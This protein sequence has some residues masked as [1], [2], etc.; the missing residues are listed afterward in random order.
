VL[1][2]SVARRA[3]TKEGAA[4]TEELVGTTAAGAAAAG[5]AASRAVRAATAA[6]L[7][8]IAAT[9]AVEAERK[10]ATTEVAAVREPGAARARS[11]RLQT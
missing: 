6:A 5:Q 7:G 9:P 4:K 2:E 11:K 10:E 8:A 3:V 1:W